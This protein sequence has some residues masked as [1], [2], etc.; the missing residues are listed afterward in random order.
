MTSLEKAIFIAV[1]AH[2][3]DKD[4]AGEAYILHPLRMMM[5]M[6]TEPERIVAVLHDVVEDS[7][8]TLEGL[9]H[10]GFTEEVLTAVDHLT[11]RPGEDYD[12][13]VRRAVQDP[14]ALTVKIADLEDNLDQTRLKKPMTDQDRARMA[15]YQRA[16][17][18]AKSQSATKEGGKMPDPR[19]RETRIAQI[20]RLPAELEKLV[21]G[22]GEQQLESRYREGS[23]TVR[24]LVHHLADAHTNGY[25]RMKLTLTEDRPTIKPWNQ[26][27]WSKLEDARTV[28]ISTS[29]DIIRGVHHR[30]AVLMRSLPD[31]A[32]SRKLFHPE[33]GELTLDELL[34]LCHAHGENHLGQ[35]RAALRR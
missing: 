12:V 33:R 35:I 2:A 7:D 1:Q 6:R 15:R 34:E 32:W 31:E 29:L 10:E 11:K 27:E 18:Y 3:D 19:Q 16:L 8:W 22:I 21:S 24:Q 14:L 28:P 9:R 13:F 26:D 20:E 5:K 25:I 17:A 30:W 23:W 4:K